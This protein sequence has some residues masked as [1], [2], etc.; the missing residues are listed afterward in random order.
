MLDETQMNEISTKLFKDFANATNSKQGT[1]INFNI[2]GT[3][4]RSKNVKEAIDTLFSQVNSL[5]AKEWYC[6]FNSEIVKKSNEEHKEYSEVWKSIVQEMLKDYLYNKREARDNYTQKALPSAFTEGNGK[7]QCRFKP[8]YTINEEDLKLIEG[9]CYYPKEDK[10]FYVKNGSYKLIGLPSDLTE[11]NNS[12]IS[13][14]VKLIAN[15]QYEKLGK[16]FELFNYLL[17]KADMLTRDFFETTRIVELAVKEGKLPNFKI[18]PCWCDK[19]TDISTLLSFDNDKPFPNNWYDVIH[20]AYAKAA[21]NKVMPSSLF[22][23]NLFSFCYGEQDSYF[24]QYVIDYKNTYRPNL[25]DYIIELFQDLPSV[26]SKIQQ[27]EVLPTVIIDDESKPA[28][29]KLHKD[30][31]DSLKNQVSL[32][33]CKILPIFLKPY[34]QKERQAIMGWA[35]TVLHPSTNES[36]NFLF[37]TGGGT[38]KTN[39]YFE[40]INTLM[41]LM[42]KPDRDLVWTMMRD[43]WVKDPALKEGADGNGISNAALVY[44]NE[45]TEKCLEEFKAMTGGTVAEG[46]RYVKRIMRENAI[47]MVSHARWLLDANTNFTIQD[48]TGAFD[49]RLFIIDRMDVQKLPKPVAAGDLKSQRNSELRAF[50]NLAK[51]CYEKI[52][53]AYGSFSEFVTTED[54]FVKNLT[55][56]YAEDEKTQIYYELTKDCTNDFITIPIKDF[57]EKVENL[58]KTYKVNENGF[59]NWVTSTSKTVKPVKLTSK[60]IDEDGKPHRVWTRVN[61]KQTP[62]YKLYK[63]KPEILQEFLEETPED[64]VRW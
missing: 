64:G 61:G 51:D 58:C 37:K 35:Y 47:Q 22:A 28:E 12:S 38:F 43:A 44:N 33:E 62:A 7:I 13:R 16:P 31:M 48:S 8:R 18:K 9:V 41:D 17:D 2:N 14:L 53:S 3:K 6:K 29:F 21:L 15:T 5:S 11:K 63:L 39:Y 19:E 30:W 23:N 24:K 4:F 54:C 45:A 56:A 40:Q 27:I 57:N 50:Y 55:Q 52:V 1:S 25:Q 20:N 32:E 26:L 46:V 10:I 49:R 59:K 60:I 36:I 42:Y 34:T